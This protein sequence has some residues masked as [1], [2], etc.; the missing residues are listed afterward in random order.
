VQKAILAVVRVQNEAPTKR[1][2]RLGPQ[3]S[4]SA[5]RPPPVTMPE[6]LAASEL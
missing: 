2:A 6:A 5:V 1:E 4:P 3:S